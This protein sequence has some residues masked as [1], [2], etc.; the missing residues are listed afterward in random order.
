MYNSLM[1]HPLGQQTCQY[2]ILLTSLLIFLMDFV[3]KNR[4]WIDERMVKPYNGS[5]CFS[6]LGVANKPL[7]SNWDK[8]CK[9]ADDAMDLTDEERL[10]LVIELLPSDEENSMAEDTP[11][12]KARRQSKGPPPKR[13]RLLAPAEDS[14][15]AS[16]DEYKP[17]A[18]ALSE[19]E[20]EESLVEDEEEAEIAEEE[21][22]LDETPVKGRKRK[23]PASNK[24]LPR[25]P[26]H[27]KS[28]SSFDSPSLSKDTKGK[29]AA[30]KCKD[31]DGVVCDSQSEGRNFNHLSYDFL[32]QDKIRDA[33]RR[34]PDDPEYDPR[35][36]YV[37]DHFKQNLTPAMR[38][39]WEMKVGIGKQYIIQQFL[40]IVFYLHFRPIILTRYCSL[41]W[42]SFMNFITLTPLWQ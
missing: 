14:D 33:K 25:T 39:W 40:L 2:F 6:D 3:K 12:P 37:P 21:E 23:L 16:G 22:E 1:I 7:D 13:R 31:T 42:E 26:A 10:K 8:S 19:S 20:V 17:E 36:L 41:K 30:F 34:R 9:E 29:L 11:T 4:A 32:K 18:E 38:Q 28:S 35:T 27:L 24:S 15:E 5:K